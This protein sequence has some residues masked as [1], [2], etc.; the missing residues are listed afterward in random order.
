MDYPYYRRA[1]RYRRGGAVYGNKWDYIAYMSGSGFWDD[2][3][4]RASRAGD[5]FKEKASRAGDVI[6]DYAH[7]AKVGSQHALG[8]VL[9]EGSNFVRDPYRYIRD[10]QELIGDVM[11]NHGRQLLTAHG[12]RYFGRGLKPYWRRTRYYGKALDPYDY[13]GYNWE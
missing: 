7:R 2:F 10:K 11:E 6:S 5:D 4:E 13:V 8:N 12:L 3:K 1:R 9:V